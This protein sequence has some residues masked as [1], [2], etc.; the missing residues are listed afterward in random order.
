MHGE[1][2][3]NVATVALCIGKLHRK[4]LSLSQDPATAIERH[5]LPI[6]TKCNL[7]MQSLALQF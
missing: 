6:Y 2:R 5:A 3:T 1:A 7:S 4:L